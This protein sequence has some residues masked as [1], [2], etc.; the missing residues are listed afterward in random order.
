MLGSVLIGEGYKPKYVSKMICDNVEQTREGKVM[1]RFI[2]IITC[3]KVKLISLL[4]Q[5]QRYTGK[6][7]S[8]C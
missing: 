6:E 8:L 4:S 1:V 7:Q 3:V 5:Q 2:D